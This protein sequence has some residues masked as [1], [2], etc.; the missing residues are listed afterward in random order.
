MKEQKTKKLLI[1]QDQIG[2]DTYPTKP[3]SLKCT[4]ERMVYDMQ[5]AH[6]PEANE[7]DTN[8]INGNNYF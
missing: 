7:N 5:Y 3:V 6:V 4:D 8:A 2:N 1:Y